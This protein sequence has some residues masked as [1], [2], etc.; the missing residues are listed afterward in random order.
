[1]LDQL[2]LI[3][4][5]FFFPALTIQT[6]TDGKL[7]LQS[8]GLLRSRS[9]TYSLDEI[10]P[11]PIHERAFAAG[12]ALGAGAAIAAVGVSIWEGISKGSPDVGL[13]FFLCFFGLIAFSLALNA[14][15]LFPKLFAYRSSRAHV[16]LFTIRRGH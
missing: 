4:R 11:A 15:R 7:L 1:M 13:A 8:K 2:G 16:L 9:Q 5:S 3:Q 10:D 12:W 6:T 14:V